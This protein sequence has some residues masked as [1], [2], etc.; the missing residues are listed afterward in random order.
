[1]KIKKYCKGCMAA[2]KYVDYVYVKNMTDTLNGHHIRLILNNIPYVY[3]TLPSKLMDD[4]FESFP[5]LFV[6]IMHKNGQIY[7]CKLCFSYQSSM[8]GTKIIN[9][10]NKYIMQDKT[11]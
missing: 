5:K 4:I 11:R 8:Y 1:M 9:K 10:L 2:Y 6:D 3:I 7:M